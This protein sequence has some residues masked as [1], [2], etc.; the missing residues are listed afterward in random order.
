M[1]YDKNQILIHYE[2]SLQFVEGLLHLT[3]EQWRSP[4]EPGKW[5]VAEVIG[6]LAPWDEFVY[7]QRL[8]YLL[9]D[10]ILPKGP[11]AEDINTHA[12]KE[13]RLK[14]KEETIEQFLQ[15][16]NLLMGAIQ[17]IED[18]KWLQSLKIGVSELTLLSYFTG[19]IDHDLHH[20]SQIQKV[21]K[22]VGVEKWILSI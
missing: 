13:S 8:P 14:S 1:Y 16:R 21:L 12:A 11:N 10:E 5:T 3:E 2:K 6:H 19:L 4:I 20:F 7:Q 17:Q 22:N 18:Q 9:A 15:S